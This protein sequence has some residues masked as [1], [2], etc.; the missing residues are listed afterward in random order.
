MRSFSHLEVINANR[1]PGSEA[2]DSQVRNS[3]STWN[4]NS[5]TVKPMR[6]Q[7]CEVFHTWKS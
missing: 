5:I 6:L 1:M 4:T 3:A 7:V 2:T